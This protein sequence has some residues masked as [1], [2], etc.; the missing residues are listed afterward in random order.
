MAPRG[1]APS[2]LRARDGAGSP[3]GGRGRGGAKSS[4]SQGRREQ[5]LEVQRGRMV[6]AMIAVAAEHG[7]SNVSVAA[8]VSRSGVSRR[9]FYEVFDDGPQCLLAA[10]EDSLQRAR[11]YVA[12]VHDPRD[13]WRSRTRAALHALLSFLEEEPA[14]GQLLVVE[15]QAAGRE[16]LERRAQVLTELIDAVDEGRAESGRT[17]ALTPLTAEGLVGSVLAVVHA[18]IVNGRTPG[19]VELTNPLMSTI[20]LP[21]L[22]AAAARQ[23]LTR[24]LPT[25]RRHRPRAEDGVSQLNGLPMRITYRTMRVLG[26]IAATPGASNRQVATAA[27]IADQGQ[28]S[29]L[30]QRLERLGLIVNRWAGHE[31]GMANQWQLTPVGEEIARATG[32]SWEAGP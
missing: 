22:G 21:Y 6:A 13:P 10:L 14:R 30:L 11:S 32:S 23:E 26:V 4:A 3:A 27:E 24:R 9:T 8:V 28:V 2:V 12:E 29:K 7:A 18:R 20:V 19:L 25:R 31:R 15:A 16:A 1:G 5:L 17:A